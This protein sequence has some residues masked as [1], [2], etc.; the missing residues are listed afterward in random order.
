VVK[1]LFRRKLF[2][3]IAD[4]AVEQPDLAAFERGDA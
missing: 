2:G 1:L 3:Q 4:E